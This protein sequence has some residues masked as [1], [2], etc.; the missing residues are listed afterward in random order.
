MPTLEFPRSDGN[1]QRLPD[2]RLDDKPDE[3]GKI[4]MLERIPLDATTSEHWRMKIGSDVAEALG[5]ESEWW[6]NP[7]S[8]FF[9]HYSTLSDPSNYVL[10]DF[11]NGYG[12]INI[13]SGLKGKH[14]VH[15]YLY[16]T[17]SLTYTHCAV[18]F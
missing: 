5:L 9:A 3:S 1:S 18:L 14:R 15:T 8:T 4:N 16:G 6:I 10:D 2:E 13:T 12:L 7:F 11:P 17:I